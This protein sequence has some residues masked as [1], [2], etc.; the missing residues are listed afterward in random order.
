MADADRAGATAPPH[1]TP[2]VP[3]VTGRRFV[4]DIDG[5]IAT[6]VADMDYASAGP[7][8]GNIRIVNRLYD[9]GNHIILFTARGT[10]TG[11]DWSTTTADQMRRWGVKHHELRFG[12]PAGDYYIDDRM[13]SLDDLARLFS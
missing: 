4:F 3:E 8:A 1:P 13:V 7:M 5:V 10:M 12:K 2:L 6:V 9:Q 11:I